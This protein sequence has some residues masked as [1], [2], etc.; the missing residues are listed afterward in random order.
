MLTNA[1]S[2]SAEHAYVWHF[3][4]LSPFCLSV[5]EDSH[6]LHTLFSH[7]VPFVLRLTITHVLSSCVE[8]RLGSGLD[9]RMS[10]QSRSASV[11]P[12]ARG[13]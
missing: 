8:V 5:K 4:H 10:G 12:G 13:S 3:V 9:T 1:R 6:A 2:H 11:S 7:L